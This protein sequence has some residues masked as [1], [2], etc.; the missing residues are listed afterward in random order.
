MLP[1]FLST[2]LALGGALRFGTAGG[3]YVRGEGRYKQL[4]PSVSD[5]VISPLRV[6]FEVAVGCDQDI[7]L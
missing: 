6:G 7:S 4:F 3:R 5:S 1:E 2:A